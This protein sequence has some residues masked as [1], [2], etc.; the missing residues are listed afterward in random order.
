MLNDVRYVRSL[1]IRDRCDGYPFTIPSISKLDALEFHDKVTY[2]IGDNGSGKSTIL[3]AIAIA[4]RINPEGGNR[5]TRFS[6]LNTESELHKHITVVKTGKR[7]PD[8]FFLR[9]E[10][11]FNLYVAAHNDAVENPGFTWSIHGYGNLKNQS[12][13]EGLLELIA[14]KMHTGVYLFDEPEGGL[15][16]DRQMQFLSEV[17]RLV[18]NGSQVIIS[19]HSPIVLAYPDSLIYHLSD[20]GAALVEYETTKPFR[21]THLFVSHYQR[22]L[23][24]LLDNP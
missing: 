22:M 23:K 6:L 5:N 13:G 16:V 9:G 7:I 21:L 10:T 14:S 8:A 20:T 18:S 12:H 19:T 24:E 3:E 17:H 4:L 15:G 1:Q 11:L 2:I